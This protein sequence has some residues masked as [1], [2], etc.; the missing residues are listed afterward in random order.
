MKVLVVLLTVILVNAT[1]MVAAGAD[2][3]VAR[4][5]NRLS[6]WHG[7]WENGL[8]R[9]IRL[10]AD[11]PAESLAKEALLSTQF[12]K[13]SFRSIV[14][15]REI[16]VRGSGR[17]KAIVISTDRGRRIILLRFVPTQMFWWNRTFDSDERSWPNKVPLPT[18]ASST[19]AADAPVAPPSGAAGH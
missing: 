10:P 15:A 6:E 17:L 18:P 1:A 12:A 3:E 16:M 4:L 19:P 2:D 7:M 13:E 14:G 11:A 8:F 9:G 5:A